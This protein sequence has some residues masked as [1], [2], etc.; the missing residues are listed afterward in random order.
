MKVNPHDHTSAPYLSKGRP[1]CQLL[2]RVPPVAQDALVTINVGDC[3]S[4]SCRVHIPAQRTP[5]KN[6]AQKAVT[7]QAQH[8]HEAIDSD[9]QTF[10]HH[11]PTSYEPALPESRRNYGLNAQDTDWPQPFYLVRRSVRQLHT[12]ARIWHMCRQA[13]SWE[14]VEEY[15][16]VAYPGSYVFRPTPSPPA[17]IFLRSVALMTPPSSTL[18]SYFLPVLLSVIVMVPGPP[19]G[20]GRSLEA[21]VGAASIPEEPTARTES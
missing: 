3:G 14:C 20:A 10:K 16:A 4:A 9:E 19:P 15:M 5:P 13:R 7:N 21:D 18:I 12:L 8:A 11:P 17:T 1:F 2:D 6:V